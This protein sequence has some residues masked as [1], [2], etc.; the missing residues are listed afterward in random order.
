MNSDVSQKGLT[1]SDACMALFES[2]RPAGYTPLS[3]SCERKRIDPFFLKCSKCSKA[4]V[5]P[6]IVYIITD[7][8]PT[9][10]RGLATSV[11]TF[12]MLKRID[13]SLTR[14]GLPRKT[15]GINVTQ[16]G[17][18][19]GATQ[20]LQQLDDH[21]LFGDRVDC[22]SDYEQEMVQCE[23]QGVYLTPDMYELVF[24]LHLKS[25]SVWALP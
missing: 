4:D 5:K 21:P 10:D 19:E 6:I 1:S 2:I 7:G 8:A 15:V 18:D 24:L 9:T 14:L 12:A 11:P 22:V 3:Y 25:L 23:K 17:F 20:F 16:I 13:E